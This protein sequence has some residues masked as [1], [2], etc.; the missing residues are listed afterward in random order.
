MAVA[1]GRKWRAREQATRA[2][3][4]S[5]SSAAMNCGRL[6]QMCETIIASNICGC[7]EKRQGGDA[8]GE[9]YGMID[10]GIRMILTKGGLEDMLHSMHRKTSG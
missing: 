2:R 10:W 1:V 6:V 3:H 9:S 5:C 4:R 8:N 7:F